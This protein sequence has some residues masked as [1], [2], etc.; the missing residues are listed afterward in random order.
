MKRIIIAIV[1]FLLL[2]T[3]ISFVSI[4]LQKKEALVDSI[5]CGTT[6]TRHVDVASKIPGRIDSLFV[7]EGD[8]VVKGQPLVVFE[9][10]EITAKV[11]QARGV[12]GAAYAKMQMAKNGSR[13]KEQEA[14]M[15]MYLQAKVQYDL[16]EKTYARVSKLLKDSVISTQEH[17]QAEAQY[18]S[19]REQMDAAKV[20]YDLAVE[21][22]RVEEKDAA[23]ALYYQAQNIYSEANIYADEKIIKSPVCGEI[24]KIVADPGEII[25]SGYPVI[26]ITD[27]S[28]IWVVIQVKEDGMTAFKKGAE[29]KGKI[30]ALGNKEFP[31]RVSFISPMADFATWRPTNQK[32]DFDIRTFEIHLKPVNPIIDL[33]AGMT[34]NFKK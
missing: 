20:K 1:I 27:T 15:K 23:Q 21:G 11:E 29:F 31:F 2:I 14:A 33:R 9:S 8:Y 7:S 26:T 18:N 4:H 28:D 3:A 19:S 13:P 16:M 6:E 22:A 5:F 34:V 24:E 12:M 30:P 32:G 25:S 17:D 10:K